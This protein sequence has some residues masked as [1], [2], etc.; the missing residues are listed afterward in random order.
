MP[1]AAR[2]GDQNEAFWPWSS[3]SCVPLTG[4]DAKRWGLPAGPKLPC[5]GRSRL[6]PGLEHAMGCLCQL[7]KTCPPPLPSTAAC[8]VSSEAFPP[9]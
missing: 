2:M 9:A 6:T 1:A 4:C 5:D 8:S 7:G 3:P